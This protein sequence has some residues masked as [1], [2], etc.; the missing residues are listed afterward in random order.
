[1]KTG[2]LRKMSLTESAISTCEGFTGNAADGDWRENF[3]KI[4]GMPLEDQQ[5]IF[6]IRFCLQLSKQGQDAKELVDLTQKVT[7]M[8]TEKSKGGDGKSLQ[9]GGIE[10]GD[11]YNEFCGQNLTFIER[12]K[13]FAPFDLDN[14]GKID[15]SE[16]LL[17]FYKNKILEGYKSRNDTTD[18]ENFAECLMKELS[19]VAVNIDEKIDSANLGLKKLKADYEASVQAAKD[20]ATTGVQ[21]TQL[22]N[23]LNKLEKKYG[24]DQKSFMSEEAVQKK[25]K[26]MYKSQQEIVIDNKAVLIKED[27]ASR[28]P[29]KK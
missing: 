6:L 16:F 28:G 18:T 14:N 19:S 4:C 7:N 22:G 25:V 10:F 11:V 8:F 17:F 15:L 3:S 12:K 27:E 24:E 20:G 26:K 29:T 2:K 1:M 13:T 9:Y 21:K 23:N 5:D